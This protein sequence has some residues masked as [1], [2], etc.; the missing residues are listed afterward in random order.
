MSLSIFVFRIGHRS[1]GRV[2]HTYLFPIGVT[3]ERAGFGRLDIWEIAKRY[4]WET[5]VA[6]VRG[7]GRGR[8][9]RRV[10]SIM[11]R[12]NIVRSPKMGGSVPLRAMERAANT[13]TITVPIANH[14]NNQHSSNENIR[15]QNLWDGIETMAALMQ[16]E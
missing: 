4:L 14:D 13:H 8:S 7:R 9:A 10:F 12:M 16:M 6:A 1:L 5:E 11:H 15:L 3:V 2:I